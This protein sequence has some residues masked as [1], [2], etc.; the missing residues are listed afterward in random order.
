[1]SLLVN[2]V[3]PPLFDAYTYALPEELCGSVEIGHKVEVPLGKRRAAGFVV[4]EETK[5]AS[6]FSYKIKNIA[7]V[8]AEYPFFN[9]EQLQFFKWIADYYGASLGSVIDVAIPSSV[10][11]KFQRTIRIREYQECRGKVQQKVVELL[12]ERGDWVD[13]NDL[14]RSIPGA[15]NTY[16][17][18]EEK[19]IIESRSEELKD[20]FLDHSPPPDWAK[21][22]VQLNE[23]QQEATT[24]IKESISKN[25][26]QPYLLYGVTGS[27][28]TEVYIE[29]IQHAFA[30]GKGVLVLVPEIALTPQLVDRFRVRL[31]SNIAVLH[32]GLGKRARW[33]GWRALLD[34][35]TP[36][37]LGARSAVF[38]PIEN[39][40]LI[41]VD[42]EHDGSYKQNDGLRYNARDSAV[43]RAK[44]HSC[45]I[46]LGSATPSL[47]SYL[48]AVTKKYIP[49]S[50]PGRHGVAERPTIDL[51]D[52]SSIRAKE[53]KTPH[54]SPQ[55]FTA[56]TE[57]IERDE[58]VFLLY[59]RRGF[60]SYLQCEKC[61]EVME[62]PNCSVTFTY[63]QRLHRLVCHYCNLRLVPPEFCGSCSSVATEQNENKHVVPGVL[64]QRGAG[65]EK[66]FDEV[67]ELFPEVSIARLDRDA[68]SNTESY[69]AILDKIRSQETKIVVGTQMIAK[70]HDLPNVTLVGIVDCDIG[71]HMPDF[72]A[73]ERTFQLLTQAAG[74]SGRSSKPGRVLL[75]TR[76][77]KH[78]SL[79]KTI[80]QDY[81]GFAKLEL[82]SRADLEY[83]PF[84]RILRIVATAK[85]QQTPHAVLEQ[86]RIA[87]NKLVESKGYQVT[88]LGPTP[89]PIE[90]IKTEWRWHLLL[91]GK[92]IT[93]LI[94]IIHSLQQARNKHRGMRI[95][96]DLDP[97]DML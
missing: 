17:S 69:K 38:A 49:M 63:H 54:I 73:G 85:D 96:F 92:K 61:E 55:L 15:A 90:K 78:L 26:F 16:K 87:I 20:H 94:N 43:V 65:T 24:R 23:K 42:E 12:K 27:G 51:V 14:V 75:Q 82:K 31:G 45:P 19:G 72:R 68:A 4:S 59:N 77:P 60:A 71:L 7:G 13:H 64:V 52:L 57:T 80:Q 97:Q 56:L 40:G 2:V 11:Q 74:R 6:E 46:V 22:E 3:I 36:I 91:K 84:S 76:L 33:D 8:S 28:K 70:G 53:M 1:M 62:C 50:L 95:T 30:Q 86:Y 39:L 5:P 18:L 21:A 10:P 79:V 32:S 44:M 37:A 25:E 58:Q 89:A 93:D 66:V 9:S 83:P 47:E 34:S 88:I 81:E 67:Q 48:N 35:R 29:S 41:I